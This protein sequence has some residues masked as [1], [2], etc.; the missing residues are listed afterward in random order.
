M[1]K[2]NPGDLLHCDWNPVIGCERFSVGCRK[3]WYIEGIFP[4]QKRVG[5]IPDHVKP[6]DVHVFPNRLSPP[7][8]KTKRGVIGVCQHGD[9]FWE[10][11][12]D[13]TIHSVL[14]IIDE[15]APKYPDN[16]Y[17]LW[18]KRAHRMARFLNAR[19]PHGLPSYYACS[20]SIENQTIADDRIPELIKIPSLRIAMMEPMLGP[21]DIS[22][23]MRSI[24]WVVVGSETG[25]DAT[26]INLQWVIDVRDYTKAAGKPFFIKQL[27]TSH[28]KPVR[29]L[30]GRTWDER[31][32]G[33]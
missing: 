31:P 27:G 4:W 1:A 17:V 30:Q 23:Y 2:N 3:C 13:S 5:N 24:D 9:L 14:D 19:Y 32:A 10:K 6:S 16:R 20:V 29:T 11:I 15:I 28:K 12:P 8:L 7:Y 22:S 21:I 25:K 18:T 26:P 33:Y